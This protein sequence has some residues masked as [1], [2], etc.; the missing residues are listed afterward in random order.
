MDEQGSKQNYQSPVFVVGMPRSGTTLMQGILCNTGRYFPVPETHYFSRVVYG[1]PEKPNDIQK[2]KICQLLKKK[3]RIDIDFERLHRFKT[4]KE[5]FEF[6]IGTFNKNQKDTFLEKTPRHVFFI[7][8]IQEFY[9]SAKFI[10]MIRE[11]KNVVS[12]QISTTRIDN[13][14]IIRLS[15]L[16]NKISSAIIDQ[17]DKKNV[18]IVKY[19]ELT[20]YPDVV[21]KKISVF[22]GIP[23]NQEIVENIAAP[24]E[25]VSNHEFWKSKNIDW[26]KIQ[27]NKENKWK[28]ALSNREANIVNWITKSHAEIHG[29]ASAVKWMDGFV[30][31]MQDI[32]K[33]L[34]PREL[35]RLFSK[36]HG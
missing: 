4:Q 5:I 16:Y 30:G 8:K 33:L 12:S 18:I 31:A 15:I 17:K 35:K 27:Q 28:T 23:Y 7:S 11:P 25:I 13:K 2:E 3:A 32:R 21:L 22:L 6:I 20:T 10:C 36:I 14:S 24:P 26:G 9:P 19:E 29:Y 1:L 34:A